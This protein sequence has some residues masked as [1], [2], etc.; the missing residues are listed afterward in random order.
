MKQFILAVSLLSS[1]LILGGCRGITGFGSDPAQVNALQ[2]NINHIVF[3]M[4]EN[5]SFDHYFGKLGEY[6]EANGF[7]QASDIDGIPPNASN[8]STDGTAITSFHLATTCVEALSPDWLE[9][10]VA[11]NKDN[12]GANSSPMDGFVI[13]SAKFAQDNGQVDQ[14]GAR[15]MGHYDWNDLPYYYFMASQFGTSDRWFSPIMSE[16]IPNRIFSIAATTGGHVHAPLADKGQCCDQI[17]TIFHALENANVSWKIY[18]TD[19]QQ[20]GTPLTDINNYW[21]QFAAQM[22]EHIVPLSQYFGDL[23][24]N[25]LPAF[26]FIQAGLGSGRDEHPGGQVMHGEGGND[27]QLGA[28]FASEIINAFMSSSGWKDGVFVLTFDEGGAFYDHVPPARAVA[29]DDNAPNDLQPRDS[30][31]EPQG[32]FTR[33][34]FRLPMIVVSP[35]AKPHYVSHTPADTT[36]IL[37]LIETRFNL[38]SLSKR[39]A[40]QFDMTE[41]FDWSAPQLKAPIPPDQPVQGRCA[42]ANLPQFGVKVP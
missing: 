15:S 30:V 42:P 25:A 7:G 27:V 22:K 36:A 39:D 6:R 18:Y 19:M 23:D 8:V 5:R 21:P 38:G 14:A 37:K 9:S 3:M 11:V 24:N 41:F 33:T 12:P 20:N 10:H 40:Y 28:R 34:G 29:P 32:D 16:S 2:S 17:P 4:Q 35:F 31:I 13:N 26:A 1:A